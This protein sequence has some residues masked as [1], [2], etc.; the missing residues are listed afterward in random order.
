MEHSNTFKLP[1][2]ARAKGIHGNRWVELIA[3]GGNAPRIEL[4]VM[5]E[6]WTRRKVA[7][8]I[9][10][11]IHTNNYGFEKIK[12]NTSTLLETVV[13]GVCRNEVVGTTANL[14]M[15]ELYGIMIEDEVKNAVAKWDRRLAS[16]PMAS[17]ADYP[18]AK[19]RKSKAR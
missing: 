8:A 13:F 2:E 10:V 3:H 17:L 12:A 11:I 6:D 15:S 1:L 9:P 14:V 5:E 18:T 19:P 7:I 4:K 16:E